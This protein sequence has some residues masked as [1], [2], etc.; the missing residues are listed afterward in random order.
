MTFSFAVANSIFTCARFQAARVAAG[1]ALLLL[2]V[3]EFVAARAD[4]DFVRGVGRIGE[5][6][7]L[8]GQRL[9]EALTAGEFHAHD[10]R[11][12]AHVRAQHAGLQRGEK[13]GV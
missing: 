9:Q 13:R 2:R 3:R 7:D 11:A 8:I 4:V 6:G 5:N 12:V 1:I 10:A